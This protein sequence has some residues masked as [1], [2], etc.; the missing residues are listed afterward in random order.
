MKAG[1]EK[2]TEKGSGSNLTP[3]RFERRETMR[4][5]I[6][7]LLLGLVVTQVARSGESPGEI[8][9]LKLG[10]R[11]AGARLVAF[12]PDG[13]LLAT[14]GQN[15]DIRIWEVTPARRLHTLKGHTASAIT[16]S[17]DGKLL[18]SATGSSVL[19]WDV[20]SGK[21]Q[22]KLEVQ[23]DRGWTDQIPCLAFRPD[24]K[25]LVGA[26]WVSNL[27]GNTDEKCTALIS[28]DVKTGK[29]IGLDE[30]D[31]ECVRLWLSAD[32]GTVARLGYNQKKLR[33]RDLASKKEF[34]VPSKEPIE[35]TRRIEV[36]LSPDG[37]L[38]AI[39][40][41]LWD[42]TTGKELATLW[43]LGS[44]D[45]ISYL[46][47]SPDGKF[48]AAVSD[49][50]VG[51]QVSQGYAKNVAISLFEVKT[52]GLV[53][54]FKAHEGEVY[55][56]AITRNGQTMASLSEDNTMKLWDLDP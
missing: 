56:L 17:P 12:S 48:V 30:L 22:G 42:V 55:S 36:A 4:H 15:T 39:G 14:A 23:M 13:R 40:G 37:K 51:Y 6:L 26:G 49:V 8:A 52:G 33:V 20:Q 43:G 34:D 19:L 21:Q 28:W 25:T 1:T 5:S 35:D 41:K 11:Q 38:A 2:G 32:G 53:F 45:T 47:F 31:K 27:R 7:P 18:A 46:S 54:A 50:V 44:R 16:F 3:F 9:T 24:G 10:S 29:M